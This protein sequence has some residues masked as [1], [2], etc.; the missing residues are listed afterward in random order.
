M[1]SQESLDTDI[2][3]D[4][5]LNDISPTIMESS[6]ENGDGKDSKGISCQNK[7]GCLDN[8]L[9]SD[10]GCVPQWMADGHIAVIGRDRE[11]AGL[12]GKEGTHVEHLKEAG[13]EADGPEI[14]P[15][16]GQDL[17]MTVRQS[18]MSSRERRLNM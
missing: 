10:D 12:H 6:W 3:T 2:S 5:V 4:A 11:R 1:S 15:K 9:V 8:K 18:T 17:R 7:N 13:E 14:K 16:D